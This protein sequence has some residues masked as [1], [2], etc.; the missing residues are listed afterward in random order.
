LKLHILDLV[1]LSRDAVH[2]HIGLAV[3]FMA[4]LL[5][6]KGKVT[7]SCVVPVLVVAIGMELFDLYDNFGSTGSMRWLN[8]L[9]D[10]I[11]TILWPVLI[12]MFFWIKE[13]SVHKS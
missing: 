13:S 1:S 2:I 6:E 5:W 10:I 4:V 7:L 12:A 3:F 11:N 9:H 8:S